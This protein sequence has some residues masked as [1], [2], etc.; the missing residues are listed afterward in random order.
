MRRGRPPG[1]SAGAAPLGALSDRTHRSPLKLSAT[2]QQLDVQELQRLLAGSDPEGA[3]RRS[4]TQDVEP[5][6]RAF[7]VRTLI[8]SGVVGDC[9]ARSFTV[10]TAL[11]YEAEVLH[12]RGGQLVAVD[13]VSL[14][15]V[16]GGF[17]VDRDV[18]S[19]PAA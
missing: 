10:S 7:V 11:A 8:F 15:G 3:L 13:Y 2:V 18:T 12:F 14:T 5:L 19:A 9:S 1:D 17:R 16:E 6:L 4:I